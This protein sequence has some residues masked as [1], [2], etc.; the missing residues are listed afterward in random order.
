[1]NWNEKPYVRE[2]EMEINAYHYTPGSIGLRWLEGIKRGSILAALCDKCGLKY[3]PPKIYCPRCFSEV[4]QLIEISGKPYLASYS[5]IYRDFDG[6]PLEEPVIIG[7]I[8]FE[9]VEGGLIHYIK[10][11]PDRISIGMKLEPIF[12]SER[13][14]SITD[15]EYFRPA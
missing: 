1:M 12:K 4:T 3:M 8:R 14:G 6:K 5:I 2:I 9:G 15:I 11:Q 7:F 10:A 13:R